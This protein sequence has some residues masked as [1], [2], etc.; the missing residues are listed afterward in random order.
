MLTETDLKKD[1]IKQQEGH[2][3][4]D[5]GLG[6]VVE[7]VLTVFVPLD[8]RLVAMQSG[9]DDDSA[10]QAHGLTLSSKRH[11]KPVNDLSLEGDAVFR[12]WTLCR[13]EA[14]SEQ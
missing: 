10:A 3:T 1:P 4:T 7:R 6:T 8:L 13:G 14:E 9:V 5:S 12:H 2:V 11:T